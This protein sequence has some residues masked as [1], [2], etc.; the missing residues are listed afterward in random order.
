M[1]GLIL[2]SIP[3]LTQ[4]TKIQTDTIWLRKSTVIEVKKGEKPEVY[5]D[6]RKYDQEILDLL[7]PEKIEKIDV[8]KG[9]TAMEKYNA[10]NVIWV[11]TK[12]AAGEEPDNRI[13]IKGVRAIDNGSPVI[14]INDTIAN[15]EVLRNMSPDDISSIEVLK[16][17]TARKL[18]NSESGAIIIKTKKK[19]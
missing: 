11:T 5:I 7:D 14:I 6:G 10:E 13:K 19:E 15:Q 9:E 1:A 16:G 3:A 12:N 8:Y 2:M 18:Y 17:E 4:E